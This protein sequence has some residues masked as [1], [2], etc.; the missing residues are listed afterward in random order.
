VDASN[1]QIQFELNPPTTRGVA[2][3]SVAPG[4]PADTAG[5]KVGDVIV[6]FDGKPTSSWDALGNAIRAHRPGDRVDVT[7]L[8]RSNGWARGTVTVALGTNPVPQT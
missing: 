7:I 4:G 8:Q 2:V 1:P 3:V 6:A 5:I